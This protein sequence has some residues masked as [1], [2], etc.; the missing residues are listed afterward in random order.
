MDKNAIT[1]E[2]LRGA[3]TALLTDPSYKNTALDFSADMRSLGGA[4][5]SAE[6]VL[7]YLQR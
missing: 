2:A 6:A 7:D 4:S 5:A 1:A 3:I